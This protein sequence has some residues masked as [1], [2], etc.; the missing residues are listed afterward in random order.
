VGLLIYNVQ[1]ASYL[2][3]QSRV[4]SEIAVLTMNRDAWASYIV[5]Y[6]GAVIDPETQQCTSNCH[7]KSWGYWVHNIFTNA[8]MELVEQ[9]LGVG[10]AVT[11]ALYIAPANATFTAA[12][13][14]TQ[15]CGGT[16]KSF[17]ASGGLNP[18]VG[19]Y[20][21][22]GTGTWTVIKAF[23]ATVSGGGTT[24]V[25]GTGLLQAATSGEIAEVLFTNKATLQ[26]SDIITITWSAAIT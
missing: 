21:S 3:E 10:G 22:T 24:D 13:A 9:D 17:P 11:A 6:P 7:I 15:C 25:W 8:G 26:T 12:V 5:Y 18:Q 14:S 19:A 4:I 1:Q 23:T 2:Q 16:D 20:A